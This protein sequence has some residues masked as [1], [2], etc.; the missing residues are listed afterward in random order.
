MTRWSAAVWA[1]RR[2]RSRWSCCRPWPLIVRSVA[3]GP[4]IARPDAVP[5]AL[6]EGAGRRRCGRGRAVRLVGGRLRLAL[7]VA[8]VA[9]QVLRIEELPL[10]VRERALPPEH[11]RPLLFAQRLLVPV[12]VVVAH[13]QHRG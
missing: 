11:D 5:H 1:P 9:V 4:M 12:G 13:L 10:L 3:S 7:D 6:H 2:A 8:E